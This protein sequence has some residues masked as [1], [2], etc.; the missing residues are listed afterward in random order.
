MRDK[1]R[2]G[3]QWSGGKLGPGE[4][5]E[6]LEDARVGREESQEVAETAAR[7][8]VGV[9]GGRELG[10]GA[11]RAGRGMGVRHGVGSEVGAK[12]IGIKWGAR[13]KAKTNSGSRISV[14]LDRQCN[15]QTTKL[16]VPTHVHTPTYI[17]TMAAGKEKLS[18]GTDV[19]VYRNRTWDPCLEEKGG[20]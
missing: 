12:R 10:Q 18:R 20:R 13:S 5:V 7:T 2:V 15:I 8:R 9:R 6:K 3:R 14:L 17:R 19:K 4:L 16:L 1:V 11:E